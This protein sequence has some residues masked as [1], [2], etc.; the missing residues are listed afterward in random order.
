[1]S[2]HV[3]EIGREEVMLDV[4]E[5]VGKQR[6]R[7]SGQ[8]GWNRTYTPPKT[9]KAEEAIARQFAAKAKADWSGFEGEVRIDIIS[10]RCLAKTNPKYWA[11]RADL[12]KPDGDNVSKLVIDALQGIAY[13]D[14]SQITDQRI[15]KMPRLPFVAG[16]HIR[17]KVRYLTETYVKEKK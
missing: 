14:D 7:S 17:I 2:W 4:A 10:W 8:G 16:N 11:G 13:K 5:I 6:P 3:R 1:M 12:G 9:H 15:R